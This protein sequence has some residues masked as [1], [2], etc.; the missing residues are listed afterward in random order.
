MQFIF[1][2]NKNPGV[3]G[4]CESCYSSGML[5]VICACKK[6]AYCN[7]A[8]RTKDEYYHLKDCDALNEVNFDN[9]IFQA[10]PGAK[11]GVVGLTNLGNTCFMNSALQCLSNT[12]ALTKYF[13][14]KKFVPEI[15]FDNPLGSKGVLAYFYAQLLNELWNK[16]NDCFSPF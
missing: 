6:V 10:V 2:F 3:F 4:R 16:S 8:C 14:D 11:K 9:I 13:L 5:K 12:W 1:S 15:N 7:E